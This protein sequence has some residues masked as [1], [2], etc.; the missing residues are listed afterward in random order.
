LQA[1]IVDALGGLDETLALIRDR[2]IL[3]KADTGI[4]GVMKEEMY[5]RVLNGI[6]DHIG[7]LAWRDRVEEKKGDLL[8]K[9]SRAVE[10]WEK[11][12]KAKL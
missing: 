7:N 4:Y 12:S 8:E 2:K 6:D 9:S 5:S 3:N 1:G 11:N 10:A